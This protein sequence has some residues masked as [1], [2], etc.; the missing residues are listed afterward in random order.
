[1]VRELNH[2][3]LKNPADRRPGPVP[4]DGAPIDLDEVQR[5]A[6]Q[7]AA[8]YTP[9]DVLALAQGLFSS[10]VTQVRLLAVLLCGEVG[11]R[12]DRA[13]QFLRLQV[14]L[15]PDPL[16]REALAHAFDMI[17]AH[18]GYERALAD[19]AD[20]LA[21]PNPHVRFAAVEG[22]RCWV[23]RPYFADS[24]EE[25]VAMLT[26]LDG[27]DSPL[28]RRSAGLALGEIAARH[29]QLF[30]P[31]ALAGLTWPLQMPLTLDPMRGD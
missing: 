21:D 24:P 16:V 19:I 30:P 9:G 12:D 1:M 31:E 22:L 28:V 17:C 29:P 15:D 4:V 25:A 7:T 23:D 8:R 26:W 18:T 11:A 20:W 13:R 27:D 2:L 6:R 14:S 10:D 3:Q 5:A